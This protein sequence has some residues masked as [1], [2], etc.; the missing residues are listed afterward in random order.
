MTDPDRDH[1]GEPAEGAEQPGADPEDGRTPHPEQPAEGD[2]A[3]AG[4]GADTPGA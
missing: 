4:G 2:P 1:T 3:A